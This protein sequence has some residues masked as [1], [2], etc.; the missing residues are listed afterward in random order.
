MDRPMILDIGCGSGV[1]TIELAR[2]CNGT[3]IGLDTDAGALQELEKRA[4][5][6]GVSDRVRTIRTSMLEMDFPDGQFD[7]VWSEGAAWPIGFSRALDNW[8]MVLRSGGYMVIHDG[9]WI[10]PDPPAEIR[11]YCEVN[12]PGIST[13]EDNLELIPRQGYELVGEFKL[14]P[15]AWLDTYFQPLKDRLPDIMQKYSGDKSALEALKREEIQTDLYIR[16]L[17]WYGSAFYV[18]RKEDP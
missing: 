9:C 15:E 1:P 10:E 12:F 13:H 17:R 18:M 14:P 3:L 11:D 4:I 2:L 8:R 6:E 7:I 5:E 16:N